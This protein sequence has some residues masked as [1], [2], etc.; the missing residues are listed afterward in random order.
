MK[1]IIKREKN[2]KNKNLF[3][4]KNFKKVLKSF[5]KVYEY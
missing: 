3:F 4:E 2:K 1:R 5:D